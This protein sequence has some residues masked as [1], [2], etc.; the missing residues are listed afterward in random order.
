MFS[1]KKMRLAAVA[2][3]SVACVALVAGSASAGTQNNGSNGGVYLY[4]STPAL[5]AAGATFAWDA[6]AYGSSSN[7]N[8][9][10]A[11]TCPDASTGVKT[12]IA[13]A[14]DERTVANWKASAASA[15]LSG[16]KTVLSPN[17]SLASQVNGNAGGVK[18]NGGSYSLGVACTSN[19]GVTVLAAFYRTISVTAG[20][21]VWTATDSVVT[22]EFRFTTQP[23]SQTIAVG[24]NATFTAA[25]SGTPAQASIKW[26][27]AES[28]A[29]TTFADVSGATTGTLVVTSATAD[30]NGDI[31]R[32]VATNNAGSVNSSSAVLTVSETTGSVAMSA[33]VVNAVD[34][35][36]SL[37]V[38]TNAS[39]TFGTP[40]LVL[41]KSTATGTMPNIT[42]ND[43]RVN[44]RP[45]WSLSASVTDFVFSTNTISKAQLGFAPAKVSATAAGTQAGATQVAGAATYPAVIATGT[46]ANAVGNTVLNGVLTFVAPQ[47]KPAGTY[48]S[49]MTL[50]VITNP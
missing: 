20:T 11:L 3:V 44:S 48:T 42:V 8:P 35:A 18:T 9:E 31:Y 43:G 22:D 23:A 5:A 50:T 12:F 2:V 16:T 32:A 21:G 27:K 47:E 45:G 49:T 28:T 1:K 29:T 24:S 40:T 39:I 36:L 15:F 19:S 4:N 46:A 34:G 25:T 10:A 6:E 37:S 17:L 13:S 30:D 33:G 7:S 14:G 26:Q 41:N 38:P